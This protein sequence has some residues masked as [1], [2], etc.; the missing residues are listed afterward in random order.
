LKILY[1]EPVSGSGAPGEVLDDRLTIAC[2]SGALRLIRLQRAGK[3]V[4]SA[5]EL[6]R[7]FSLPKGS[8]IK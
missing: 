4:M 5:H 8:L 7:G 6:L 2:G 1:A 3:S